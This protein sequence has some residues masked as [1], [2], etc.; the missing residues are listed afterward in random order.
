MKLTHFDRTLIHGLGLVS[1][2]RL[3]PNDAN[4]AMYRRIVVA[5]GQRASREGPML[6]LIAEARRIEEN[7]GSHYGIQRMIGAAMDAFDADMMAA[8]WEQTRGQR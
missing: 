2:S 7:L 5:A 6:P 3:T 8:H 4:E 1:R